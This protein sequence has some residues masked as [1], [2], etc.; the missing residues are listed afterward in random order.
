MTENKS[1]F[2][3]W[4]DTTYYHILYHNRDESEAQLFIGNLIQHLQLSNESVLDLACGKGRHA[5]YLSEFGLNVM[6]V[7]LSAQSIDF[8][9]QH[10]HSG[11]SFQVHDM[12]DVI[13]NVEFDVIFNLFTSFGYFDDDLE[14]HKVLQ[15]VSKMLIPGGRLVIDFMNAVKVIDKLV[16]TEKKDIEGIQFDLKRSYDGK[17][18]HKYISFEDVGVN[19]SYKERVRAF[20]LE[21]F[22]HM[23]SLNGFNVMQTF[24]DFNLNPFDENMSD[25]LIIV[26]QK[27]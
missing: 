18:I 10:S 8:A 27:Q 13:P 21:D 4:F 9:R 12:R 5:K 1:W 2:A 19:H 11:L 26:A 22:Q 23:L 17:F 14:N 7:D 15:A 6:G 20:K 3:S 16:L 24:G 25:R